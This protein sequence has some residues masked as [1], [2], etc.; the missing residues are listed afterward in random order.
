MQ[1]LQFRENYLIAGT[2][3]GD[4]HYIK[5]W[6]PEQSKT[7]EKSA[8]SSDRIDKLCLYKCND[9]EAPLK[10]DFSLHSKFIFSITQKGVFSTYAVEN[11]KMF[12]SQQI[13]S[14]A[15][16]NAVINMVVCKNSRK[17]F[18]CLRDQILI[19]EY[20]EGNEQSVKKHSSRSHQG[21]PYISKA[22]QLEKSTTF[23]LKQL[24]NPLKDEF[25]NSEFTHFIISRD[26]KYLA[27]V[28]LVNS[29]H[30]IGG[31]VSSKDNGEKPKE[32]QLKLYEIFVDDL[33]IVEMHIDSPLN[34]ASIKAIDFSVD[35]NFLL[36]S[37]TSETTSSQNFNYSV[38][39]I[40]EGKVYNT[41]ESKTVKPH[42]PNICLE[43]SP[44]YQK[45]SGAFVDKNK[46]QSIIN[47]TDDILIVS[48]TQG[49]IRI[50]KTQQGNKDVDTIF[51]SCQHLDNISNCRMSSN[52][53]LISSSSMDKC[54]FI[55]QLI[56]PKKKPEKE[57]SGEIDE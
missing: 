22:A 55:W 2:I 8:E 3:N 20:Q 19:F 24:P 11:F 39:N 27:L 52:N 56:D 14:E 26:E 31:N 47:Y 17:I 54:I 46:A 32:S 35:C 21:Y 6:S 57:H 38:M 12:H 1:S 33:K 15:S 23:T 16:L 34:S 10:V 50:F 7:T 30:E 43:E 36:I 28:Y 25:K 9:T 40:N 41:S 37:R 45:I 18:I 42:F 48:D 4:I 44:N 29:D 5:I 53:L 49:I 13:F 51:V